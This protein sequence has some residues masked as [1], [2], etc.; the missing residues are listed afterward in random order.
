MKICPVCG[1]QNPPDSVSCSACGYIL[2]NV[3]PIRLQDRPEPSPV[4]QSVVRTD[5]TMREVRKSAVFRFGEHEIH[6]QDGEVIG[7]HGKGAEL[8]QNILEV[9]RRHAKITFDGSDVYVTDLNSTNGVYVDGEL[10]RPGVPVK[11]NIGAKVRLCSKVTLELIRVQLPT[12]ARQQLTADYE[13]STNVPPAVHP[14]PEKTQS[15]SPSRSSEPASQP[16]ASTTRRCKNCG[17]ELR[18]G[19]RICPVCMEYVD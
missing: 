11:L 8:F 19:E 14:G 17:R 16:V 12:V 9:S 6:V 13:Q 1:T 2:T 3:V 15:V 7:R 18:E 10:I 4:A 5:V